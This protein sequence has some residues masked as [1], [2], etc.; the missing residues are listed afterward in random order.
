MIETI[1]RD[2]LIN[3]L[4]VPVYLEK[5][6]SNVPD[7]YVLIDHPGGNTNEHID[8]AVVAIQS[9]GPTLYQAAALADLVKEI[10][11]EPNGILTLSSVASVKLNS[12]PYNYTRADT[13]E[14]RYQSVFEI[15]YY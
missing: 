3:E 5:P 11:I 1:L 12:G 2:Y 4:P 15:I 14:Y 6:A 8:H 13:K 10:M 7:R 9:Y